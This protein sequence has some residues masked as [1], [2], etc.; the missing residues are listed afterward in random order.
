LTAGNIDPINIKPLLW[1]LCGEAITLPVAVAYRIFALTPA[2]H[3]KSD[4]VPE[5]KAAATKPAM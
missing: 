3:M 5:D 4:L 2:D 1:V